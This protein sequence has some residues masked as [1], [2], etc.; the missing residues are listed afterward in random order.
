MSNWLRTGRFRSNQKR[1]RRIRWSAC[2]LW[3][4]VLLALLILVSAAAGGWLGY[5]YSD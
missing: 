4:M 3:F 5:I 1:L 2:D